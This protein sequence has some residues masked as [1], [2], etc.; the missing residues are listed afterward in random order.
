MLQDF[1]REVLEHLTIPNVIANLAQLPGGR[2]K[3]TARFFAGDWMR[4]GELL[5]QQASEASEL[6]GMGSP[7]LLHGSP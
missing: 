1:N 7:E 2:P 6:I 4:V 3:P 5:T